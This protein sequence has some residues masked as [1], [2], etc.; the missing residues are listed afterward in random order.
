M[1][2]SP[3]DSGPQFR[4]FD[5]QIGGT[6][7]CDNRV[8][9]SRYTVANFLCLNM[10]EQFTKAANVYFLFL[11]ILQTLPRVTTSGNIPSILLPLT[12]VVTINAIKDG[13]EDYRRHVA[14]RE[15]NDRV[16]RYVA[17]QEK[18]ES[19]IS[20]KVDNEKNTYLEE[21]KWCDLRVGNIIALR[22]DDL[23][24]ADFVIIASSHNEGHVYVETMNL[25]GETNLKTKQA[26]LALRE[27]VDCPSS[28]EDAAAK[29]AAL[30]G[31]VQC[32]QPNE[33]LYTFA[34][35]FKP[36]GTATTIALDEQ[37]IVLRGCKIKNVEWL[38]GFVVYTGKETKIM[39][40]SK[41]KTGRKLSHLER[42]VSRLTLLMFILQ[43]SVC[44][45]AGVVGAV[46]GEHEGNRA[47]RYLPLVNR[48]GRGDF[49]LLVVLIR[50]C[51]FL[52]IFSNFI[53]I[54]LLVSMN[55]VKLFQVF[56]FLADQD[57]VHN[58]IRCMPRTSDLNEELGQIEYV[59][60]DKT[61]TLTCNIM[62]FKKFCVQGKSY[63]SGITE[64][65]RQVL[66]RMGKEVP[67][68]DESPPNQ[69]VT[70]QV[71]LHD[72]ELEALLVEKT[73]PKYDA[74]REFLLHLAINHEVVVE[75]NKDHISYSASSP[76]EA[77]LCYGA[78]HMGFTFQAR[79]S[80]RLTI[81]EPGG[82]V[83][84][85]EILAILK[86]NSA[87][88]RSSVIV[89][90]QEQGKET[91]RLMLLTKG[92][93]SVILERLDPKLQGTDELKATVETLNEYAEDGL[94]TLC[95]AGRELEEKE[96]A[97][98]L[99]KHHEA[100]CE[101]EG[102]QEKMDKVAEEI[103]KK[104]LLHGI[105]GIEDRLQEQV[106]ETIVRLQQAGVKVWMLTG[107]KIET[108]INIGIATGLLD[109]DPEAM[110]P[111]F[112]TG[113]FEVDGQ[114]SEERCA[115]HLQTVAE[116]ALLVHSKGEMFEGMVIDGKCLEL[117]LQAEH[118][119]AF[120]SIARA[121]RT[122]ICCRVSPKQKGAVVRLIKVREQAITLAIGDGANDCNMIES[123]DVGI[124]IRGLEGLQAFNVSDYGI[125]QFRF[126]QNLMLIHG[127][128]CYRRSATLA[129][130]M[131][132]KNMLVVFPQY[133]FGAVSAFSGQKLFNDL[134]YQ[135]YNVV[136]TM[137]PI[138]L[139]AILDQDVSKRV[140]LAHPE[141]Y[142]VG[143]QRGYLNRK[144]FLRWILLGIGQAALVFCIPYYAMSNGNFIHEDGKATD[145]WT[146]G[147]CM[148]L[149]VVLIVNLKVVMESCYITWLTWFG[150]G[151]SAFFWAIEQCFLSGHLTINVMD[152]NQHGA[153]HR[154]FSA[155]MFHAVM[156]TTIFSALM[157]D[158]KMK[159]IVCIFFPT[160]LHKVQA[161]VY[162]EQCAKRQAP[163]K[164][165]GE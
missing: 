43:I 122:V 20:N 37:H 114:Y 117:A 111:T 119:E 72:E 36:S 88:K 97:E 41:D 44:L 9:T 96:V 74:I 159:S 73:G 86:F 27:L 17:N 23:V 84:Q 15:E 126:L 21:V 93:D 65:R 131:F 130:Y 1:A 148:Y 39:K 75:T 35:N 52:V 29:A 42:D 95:L 66:Q 129:L 82:G 80:S 76:D 143:P 118:Q 105:T 26:P 53:P 121:C 102:R 77:A 22:A 2:Q 139:F 115:A 165:R 125:S 128:W 107:D 63:G 83:S 101:T 57:M 133:F 47:R 18:A 137:M 163:R 87:R 116:T 28:L 30:R 40:N 54:S 109:A 123:A 31:A 100:S 81:E 90:F 154:L 55:L 157:F 85:V 110:R 135:S 103:E 11:S 59:F 156:F 91:K 14:D 145:L 5:V 98:F 160:T 155:P 46:Q 151:F 113:D 106:S 158:W 19:N 147:V 32:E 141:L 67:V 4:V 12:I 89:R 138:M 142:A 51:T 92:A 25:D 10:Y 48:D 149:I 94:R 104:L 61:G 152:S 144:L 162:A 49:V 16:V 62:E 161:E 136:H 120:V 45:I 69:R 3:A 99:Q 134:L 38:I 78:H 108:A 132:Y 56:F 124:G 127:R 164:V 7:F 79:D 34:G 153:V 150:L 13:L 50:F 112:S 24:P 8:V 6:T 60:S 33:F 71:D 58:G 70:P 140:S 146:M 64:I 68:P